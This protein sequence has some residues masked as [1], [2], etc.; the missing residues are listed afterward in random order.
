MKKIVSWILSM[1]MLL[2]F[3]VITAPIV[4]AAGV[5]QRYIYD[6]E[7]LP[8]RTIGV[9]FIY[10]GTSNSGIVTG[11]T[12]YYGVYDADTQSWTQQPVTPGGGSTI[13]AKDATMALDSSGAPHVGYVFTG[14]DTYDDIGYTCLS[15]GSWTE[16]LSFSSNNDGDRTDGTLSSPQIAVDSSGTAHIAYIDSQGNNELSSYSRHPDLMYRTIDGGSIS[17]SET[18]VH[19]FCENAGGSTYHQNNVVSVPAIT[20]I[21]NTA[22]IGCASKGRYG[23]A[24]DWGAAYTIFPRPSGSNTSFDLYYGSSSACERGFKQF[25]MAADGT[26]SYTLYYV[27]GTTTGGFPAWLH[28]ANG[29]AVPTF[30]SSPGTSITTG[31]ITTLGDNVYAAGINASTL[32]LFQNAAP[33]T[34]TLSTAL[35]STHTRM[36]TVVTGGNQYILYTGNDTDK[37]LFIASVPTGGGDLSEYQVP[38]K[39]ASSSA[40]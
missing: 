16:A 14:E 15:E 10:G 27:S 25:A 24:S 1:A 4:R 12:L 20:C 8:D 28:I 6:A 22:Y 32:V 9:L 21:G 35:S 38:N 5:T 2:S 33:T 7:A 26:G 11:G 13:A 19:G 36:A 18:I 30:F 3:V 37:S 31:D 34:K 29:T 23:G 17:V 39:T 40:A